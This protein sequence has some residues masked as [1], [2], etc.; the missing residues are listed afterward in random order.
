M[1]TVCPQ[2]TTQGASFDR[3]MPEMLA[4]L[5]W[6][7]PRFATEGGQLAAGVV[8]CAILDLKEAEFGWQSELVTTKKCEF[9][10][11][12]INDSIVFA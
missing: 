12:K 1:A 5:V 10:E 3:S 6:R 9:S 4:V 8:Q 2:W 11:G 7:A